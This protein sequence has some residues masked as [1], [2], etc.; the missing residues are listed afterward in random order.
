MALSGIQRDAVTLEWERPE[1]D[2]GAPLT[3]YVIEKRDARKKRWSY[4]H[5]VDAETQQYTVPGLISGHDYFFRIRPVNLVGLG[6][7][8]Q[9]DE[10]VKV[11]S[12]YSKW[13]NSLQPFITSLCFTYI[14]SIYVGLSG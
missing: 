14:S 6:D 3:G 7:A 8:I 10:A 4:V 1:F 5:K 13:R 2:G 9:Q 12:P 11:Q